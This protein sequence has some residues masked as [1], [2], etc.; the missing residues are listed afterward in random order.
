MSNPDF[1]VFI[2]LDAATLQRRLSN[3]ETVLAAFQRHADFVNEI[4]DH[5]EKGTIEQYCAK[6]S[7]SIRQSTIRIQLIKMALAMKEM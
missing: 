2:S 6:W 3:E 7:E 4:L 1:A 5:V